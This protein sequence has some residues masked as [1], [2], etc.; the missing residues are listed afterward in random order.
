MFRACELIVINKLDLLPHLETDLDRLLYNISAVNP[1]ATTLLVSA[2]TG[3]GVGGFV[4]WLCSVRS[5]TGAPAGA[6]A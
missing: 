3:A 1:E 6:A 4:E 5:R 2:R